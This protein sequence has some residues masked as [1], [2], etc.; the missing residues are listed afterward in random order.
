M[1]LK[2]L[3]F[4]THVLGD[5]NSASMDKP[6]TGQFVSGVGCMHRLYIAVAKNNLCEITVLLKYCNQTSNDRYRMHFSLEAGHAFLNE[7][8]FFQ[9]LQK[10]FEDF[11]AEVNTLGQSKLST[12][13]QLR[14]E[15]KSAEGPRR[16]A[17][18]HKL[19]DDLN[20]NVKIRAEVKF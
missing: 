16:E 6:S 3:Q 4:L 5:G 9:M 19:W 11:V 1:Q 18:L 17:A 12:V 10:K 14:Q 2:C 8:T 15:V 7:V 20:Q 13:Q